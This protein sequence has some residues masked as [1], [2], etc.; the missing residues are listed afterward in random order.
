MAFCWEGRSWSGRL[1][2]TANFIKLNPRAFFTF[3][4]APLPRVG[5][6]AASRTV[7]FRHKSG[8]GVSPGAPEL[9]TVKVGDSLVRSGFRKAF[10]TLLRT[11]TDGVSGASGRAPEASGEPTTN[12]PVLNITRGGF[13]CSQSS[14][15]PASK[16]T[17]PNL[18]NS[19]AQ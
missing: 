11:S 12:Q 1:G 2:V 3:A 4:L 15:E 13:G 16:Q 10:G 9:P 6:G 5:P 18:R 17:I 14:V 8:F 7:V 19:V